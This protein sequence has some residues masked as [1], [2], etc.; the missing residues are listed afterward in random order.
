MLP[1][2]AEFF[3][4]Q[5]GS[6]Q[7]YEEEQRI[8]RENPVPMWRETW[9]EEERKAF[10]EAETK[11]EMAVLKARH[12]RRERRSRSRDLLRNSS[13]PVV[14]W[15]A[16]DRVIQRDYQGYRDQVLQNLPMTREEIDTFGDRQGWCGDYERMLERAKEAGVLPE[17]TP[18]LA[19]IE[20]LVVALRN[21]FGGRTATYRSMINAKLPAI[22]ES[23]KQMAA[24][25]EKAEAEANKVSLTHP[26]RSNTRHASTTTNRT[27][28]PDGRF[29]SV[30]VAA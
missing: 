28:T 27:R 26:A 9:N 5:D 17:P 6:D 16:T 7:S 3:A 29:A 22:L 19:D 23:A 21:H 24:E 18:P 14:R 1:E 4:N 15:L 11:R 10:Y 13:D 25:R 12:E 30:T 20:P 8:A 2:V